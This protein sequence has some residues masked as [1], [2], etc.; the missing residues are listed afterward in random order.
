M[1]FFLIIFD[2]PQDVSSDTAYLWFLTGFL[3]SGT[4]L[5]AIIS[6]SPRPIRHA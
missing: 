2:T 1:N 3:G 6:L 4:G 5:A